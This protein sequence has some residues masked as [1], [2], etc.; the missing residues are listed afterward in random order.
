MLKLAFRTVLAVV[1]IGMG[2]TGADTSPDNKS[3]KEKAALRTEVK[4]EKPQPPK[5]TIRR[6]NRE[7][8]FSG[9][10]ATYVEGVASALLG[11]CSVVQK[12]TKDR[13]TKGLE[14][15]HVRI[16]Y[17][18]PRPVGV[19]TGNNEEVL[20]VSEIVLPMPGGAMP[21]GVLVRCGDTY[22]RFGKYTPR[23][24]LLLQDFIKGLK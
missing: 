13:W 2:A 3:T 14:T 11:S 19:T 21:K 7:L 15:E 5:V 4:V 23:E 16:V 18:R 1:F 6:G 22:Q 17:A 20:Q 12:E 9:G 10:L 8:K 24:A